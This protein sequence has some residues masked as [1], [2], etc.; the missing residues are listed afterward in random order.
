MVTNAEQENDQDNM[1]L[2]TVY[3]PI[4]MDEQLKLLAFNKS[5]SK[6]ELIRRA[7]RLLMSEEPEVDSGELE[8]GGEGAEAGA[9]EAGAGTGTVQSR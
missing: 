4:E 9:G 1:V 7:V 8:A 5:T 3:F 2:R 6:G